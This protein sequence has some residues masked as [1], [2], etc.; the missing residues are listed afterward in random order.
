MS[1]VVDT[2]TS[3]ELVISMSDVRYSMTTGG[4]TGIGITSYTADGLYKIDT[5][6]DMG[7]TGVNTAATLQLIGS[8][9]SVANSGTVTETG[10]ATFRFRVPV[11]VA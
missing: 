2:D 10:S 8:G 5:N 4:T 6:A 9:I 7:L 3:S 1:N 11:P